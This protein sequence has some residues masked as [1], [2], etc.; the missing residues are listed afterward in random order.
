MQLK[1]LPVV[2]ANGVIRL[3]V[4]PEGS[5]I[6]FNTGIDVPGLTVRRTSTTVELRDGET[7]AIAGLFQQ[8]YANNARQVPGLGDVPVLGALFRSSRWRRKETELVVLVTPRMVTAQESHM[9]S[10]DPL[11]V[12]HE[13][14]AI[15]LILNGATLDQPM[16]APVGGI[17]GP[18]S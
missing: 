13:P 16:A 8:E 3:K 1:F 5:A 15:D 9:L 17:R 2:G 18:L 12:S 7:F 10:P 11:R 6:D 4:A 14:S